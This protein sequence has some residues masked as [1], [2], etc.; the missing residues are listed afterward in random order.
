M[1]AGEEGA[2]IDFG[3]DCMEFPPSSVDFIASCATEGEGG[4][5]SDR[6]FVLRGFLLGDC[7]RPP[8]SPGLGG[9]T[10]RSLARRPSDLN[11]GSAI[12]G[13]GESGE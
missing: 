7:G 4:T 5:F 11:E 9:T 2:D 3:V 12:M 10:E 1:N 8:L 6:F 13:P